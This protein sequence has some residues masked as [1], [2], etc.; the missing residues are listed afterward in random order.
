M[1]KYYEIIRFHTKSACRT[2]FPFR[3]VDLVKC[4]LLFELSHNATK[5]EKDAEEV[6]CYPCKRLVGNLDRQVKRTL[7]ETP[8]RKLNKTTTLF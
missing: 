7:A 1:K 3:R 4:E 2:D 8:T 5:E 6:K